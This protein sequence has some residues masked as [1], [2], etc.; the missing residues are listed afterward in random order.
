MS[1]AR[2]SST[3]ISTEQE[4]SRRLSETVL[5]CTCYF[6]LHPLGLLASLDLLNWH[7]SMGPPLIGRFVLVFMPRHLVNCAKGKK[8]KLLIQ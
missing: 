6:Q 5:Y 8:N 7:K 3:A 1:L 2:G 4:Y